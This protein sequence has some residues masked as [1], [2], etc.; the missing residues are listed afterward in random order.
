MRNSLMAGL[1]SCW[2]AWRWQR[3]QQS[4]SSSIRPWP[5]PAEDKSRWRLQHPDWLARETELIH[6][7]S[8]QVLE[9]QSCL[10]RYL[11]TLAVLDV[12]DWL[13][14][15]G[16]FEGAHHPA[17]GQASAPADGQTKQTAFCWLDVGAKNWSYV[18]ALH[19]FANRHFCNDETPVALTG[20]ELDAY[21]AYVDGYTRADY[22][23]RF[24]APLA[25]ARYLPG[26]V[27]QHQA[28]Y[29]FIS[30]FLPFVLLEPC[31]AWGLSKAQFQ[32]Q[33]ML[34]HLLSLLH[35]GGVLLVI[36][37][38]AVEAQAQWEY[39]SKLSG[40]SHCWPL[41][42]Q[43]QPTVAGHTIQTDDFTLTYWGEQPTTFLAYQHPRIVWQ[44]QTHSTYSPR[45]PQPS[46]GLET[47]R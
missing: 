44:C 5:E 6:R 22:A 23:A 33:A 11:E 9:K 15:Q 39:F 45:C 4:R 36:N 3:R 40:W 16:A 43:T 7:Y 32:P 10:P 27:C 35:P 38:G 34:A 14:L 17:L 2:N 1:H 20:V 37:Q 47:S 41:G 31:L 42:V 8:L 13:A 18:A 30:L 46:F 25:G 26:D 21:R 24:T 28:R 19:S 29:H 12:L